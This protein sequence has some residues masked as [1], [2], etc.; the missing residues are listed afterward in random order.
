M[1]KQILLNLGN[2]VKSPF[3][4]YGIVVEITKRNI[5]PRGNG[6]YER[7]SVKWIKSDKIS[8]FPRI[9]SIQDFE[10]VA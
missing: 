6:V 7:I 2:L 10:I 5:L 3:Y 1:R 9:H 4:G 8:Y